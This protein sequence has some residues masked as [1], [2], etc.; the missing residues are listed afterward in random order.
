MA[1][2]QSG[3]QLA[4]E[5][6]QL[7]SKYGAAC[8]LSR[9]GDIEPAWQ[10]FVAAIDRLAAEQASAQAQWHDISTAP[11][12]GTRI[13]LTNGESVAEGSWLHAEP[14]IRERRDSD[15]R[16]IDQDESD[17]FDGWTDCIGGMTPDPTG[18]MHLPP[19][20]T[21]STAGGGVGEAL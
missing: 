8:E 18:W 13:I 21:P 11:K 15:G 7:A 4:E 1:A 9:F 2:D 16:Y 12:D 14:Y 19:I 5:A 20:R 6:K 3:A 10:A 17:G